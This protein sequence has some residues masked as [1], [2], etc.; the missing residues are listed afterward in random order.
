MRKISKTTLLSISAAVV[1]A[2]TSA[3]VYAF[4]I[5]E[6]NGGNVDGSTFTTTSQSASRAE[7]RGGSNLG[8]ARASGTLRIV[9]G[10]DR[11]SIM[12]VLNVK[13]TGKTGPSEPITQLAIRKSGSQYVFYVVQG[14]QQCGTTKYNANTNISVSVSVAKGSTPV[15]TINGSK[16]QKANPDGD[17][18]GTVFDAGKLTSGRYTYAKMGAYNTSSASGSTRLTWTSVSI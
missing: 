5:D 9:S 11:V 7:L 18:G 2:G 16:C 14:G 10:G 4:T 13:G 8:T 1:M 12:Q 6:S 3:A 17:R 15:Y